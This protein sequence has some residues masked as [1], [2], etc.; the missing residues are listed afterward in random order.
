MGF[1][2]RQVVEQAAE[3]NTANG[4]QRGNLQQAGQEA[5]RRIIQRVED[6]QTQPYRQQQAA[7][8][9]DP[10]RQRIGLRIFATRYKA[11]RALGMLE[12]LSAQQQQR[13]PR[14]PATTEKR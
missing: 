3:Q 8:R 11:C 13:D 1:T 10:Q 2:Q 4:G 7:Q 12:R 9:Q 14:H 5:E 6:Q